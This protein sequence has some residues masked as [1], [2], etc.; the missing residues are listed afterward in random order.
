MQIGFF[1]TCD[2]VNLVFG[3]KLKIKNLE[4]KLFKCKLTKK[5]MYKL[6]NIVIIS[7]Y[8]SFNSFNSSN[9]LINK[10]CKIKIN[11]KN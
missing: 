6:N 7:M 1:G 5:T 9:L 8:M 10:L 2:N 4:Y 11:K 3:D